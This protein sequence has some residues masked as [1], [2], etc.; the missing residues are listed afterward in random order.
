M[1]TCPVCHSENDNYAT[2]CH[3]CKAFLQNRIPNLD[4]FETVWGV[5]ESP[6]AT[7][8]NITLAEHKNYSVFLFTLFGISLSFTGFWYFRLGNRFETLLELMMWALGTGVL[9][10]FGLLLVLPITYHMGAKVLGGK[11]RFRSS[12]GLLSYS[13]VPIAASL[14]FVLPVELLTFGMYLF[15]ANPHPHTIKPVSYIALLSFDVGVSLWSIVLA[16][17]A[18]SVGHQISLIK[19]ILVVAITMTVLA[20]VFFLTPKMLRL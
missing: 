19:A 10:G 1:I 14:F 13:V 6:R 8:H 2:V 4:L 17:L 15:T 20:G 5:V 3:K 16:V 7:F 12:L 18:T 11:T 9:V